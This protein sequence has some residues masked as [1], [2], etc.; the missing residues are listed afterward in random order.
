MAKVVLGLFGLLY[1]A[2]GVW[3]IVAPEMTSKKVGLY[4]VG[5]AGKSEFI[6]VYGGLEIALGV[7]F[8]VCGFDPQLNRAGLLLAV[9]SSVCLAL[10]RTATVLLVPCV[11]RSTFTFYAAEVAMAA[12]AG[13]AFYIH[14]RSAD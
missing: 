1:A 10:A 12:V 14:L 5:A 8:L 4:L 2:L 3:C 6:V 13:V 9:I 7:F 11:P